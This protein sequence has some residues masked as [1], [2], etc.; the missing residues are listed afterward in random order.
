MG[1][2]FEKVVDDAVTHVLADAYQAPPMAADEAQVKATAVAATLP[3]G[4]TKQ[5]MPGRFLVALL[6]FLTLVGAGA[7]TDAAHM[8]A[9]SAALFGFAGS[10][11]GVVTAFLGV[12]KDQ[13]RHPRI[14]RG[15]R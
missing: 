7:G 9:S 2:F 3:A 4:V 15:P 12:E 13:L 5:F 11:F 1:M 14:R 8:T 6:L 10:V